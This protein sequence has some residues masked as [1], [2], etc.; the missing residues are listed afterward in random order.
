MNINEFSSKFEQKHRKMCDLIEELTEALE[1]NGR[2]DIKSSISPLDERPGPHFRYKEEALYPALKEYYGRVYAKRLSDSHEGT[3][4]TMR[5]LHQR[6]LAYD[7]CSHINNREAIELTRGWI[8]PQVS[9]C[10]GLSI[11]IEK[12][13]GEALEDYG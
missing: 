5:K 11:T 13:P 3:I 10:E 1:S 8:Q 6:F 9:D 2:T 4:H 7:D 12:I